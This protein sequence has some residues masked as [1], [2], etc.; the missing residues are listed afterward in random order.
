M[1][2]MLSS[3]KPMQK[4]VCQVKLLIAS[5]LSTNKRLANYL[6]VTMLWFG[7]LAQNYSPRL[8]I[9]I[10]LNRSPFRY[11]EGHGIHLSTN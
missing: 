7:K 3:P 2:E 1:I 5:I 9:R 8:L 4:Q 11:T 6:P 10:A